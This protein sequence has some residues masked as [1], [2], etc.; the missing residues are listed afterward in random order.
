[1]FILFR[2]RPT[3]RFETLK[4][5]LILNAEPETNDENGFVFEIDRISS[6]LLVRCPTV[7]LRWYELVLHLK[8]SLG[9]LGQADSALTISKY[10]SSETQFL[11]FKISTY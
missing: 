1:M 11:F 7:V 4:N 6:H 8:N 9:Y 5:E 10:V 2:F 3:G